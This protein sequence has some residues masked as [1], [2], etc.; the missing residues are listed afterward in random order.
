VPEDGHQRL[1]V[2]AA[3]DEGGG[4]GVA[5]LMRV[6]VPD[7]GGGGGVVETAADATGAHP[8]AVDDPQEL[9]R[10]AGAWVEQRP[11]AS[12]DGG[13]LVEGGQGGVVEGDGAFGVQLAERDAQPGAVVAVVDEAVEFEVEELAEAEA[14][15]AQ[16]ADGEAGGGISESV[17]AGHQVAVS[18]GRERPRDCVGQPG[19]IASMHERPCGPVSPSP[20]GEVFEERLEGGHGVMLASDRHR[21]A[22]GSSAT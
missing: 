6:D 14:G 22:G 8:A 7:A 19:K 4:V 12:S 21:V 3:V 15:A 5:Q 18:V 9:D 16:D 2:H 20:Q 10:A 13:P 17:D 11:A 1:E